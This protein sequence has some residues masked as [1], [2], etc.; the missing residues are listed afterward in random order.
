MVHSSPSGMVIVVVVVVV[1]VV[2]WH[3]GCPLAICI[4]SC[5]CVVCHVPFESEAIRV[6]EMKL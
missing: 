4:A 3:H 2:C 5:V 6:H 1:V